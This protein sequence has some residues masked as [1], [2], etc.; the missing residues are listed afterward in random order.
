L[1]L[2]DSKGVSERLK[3]IRSY[4]RLEME[5]YFAAIKSLDYITLGYNWR[6]SSITAALGFSQMKLE[7]VIEMRRRNVEYLERR[8]AYK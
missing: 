4:G 7:N 2:T 8:L 6:M 1:F 5:P 3:P